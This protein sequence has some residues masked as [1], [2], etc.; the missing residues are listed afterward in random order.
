MKDVPQIKQL[1]ESLR[2]LKCPAC[3]ARKKCSHTLCGGCYLALPQ[4]MQ[5]AL[6]R[7]VGEGY[8]AAVTAAL[9]FLKQIPP[10]VSIETANA[11][12]ASDKRADLF[13]ETFVFA[14]SNASA[15]TGGL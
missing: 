9:E 7:R 12:P 4:I 8:E 1:I 5:A 13:V 11:Q 10:A 2:S 6:Y 3:R 15:I 14:E